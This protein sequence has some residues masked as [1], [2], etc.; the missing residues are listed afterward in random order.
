MAGCRHVF[1]SLGLLPM[2]SSYV[3]HVLPAAVSW[4]EMVFTFDGYTHPLPSSWL[5]SPVPVETKSENVGQSAC[6]FGFGAW[7][8]ISAM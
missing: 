2:S 7:P 3:R 5:L 8:L 6:V 1:G 4:S